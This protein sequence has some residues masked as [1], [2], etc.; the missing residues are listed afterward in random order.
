MKAL[1]TV[2]PLLALCGCLSPVSMPSVS[3][4]LMEFRSSSAVV[5]SPTYGVVRLSQVIVNLPY[6]GDSLVVLRS[7]GTVSFDAHNV[8]AAPP[9]ALMKGV[10]VSALKSSGMFAGVI[11]PSSGASA[12]VSVELIVNRLALDCRQEGVRRAVAE[13]SVRLLD[14]KKIVATVEGEGSADASDGDYGVAFSKAASA[15]VTSALSK[16]R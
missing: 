8:F 16:L 2:F 11:G 4:W 14:G 15:A 13:L 6:A 9:A 7:N 10:A 12:A 5:E 3:H 1:L